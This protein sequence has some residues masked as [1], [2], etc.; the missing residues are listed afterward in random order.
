MSE[1]SALLD[2]DL[3][4]SENQHEMTTENTINIDIMHEFALRNRKTSVIN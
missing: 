2:I 3:Y 4:I 1:I